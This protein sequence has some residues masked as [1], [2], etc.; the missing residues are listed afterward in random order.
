MG[1]AAWMDAMILEGASEEELIDS[2]DD[3]KDENKEGEVFQALP[4]GRR[5]RGIDGKRGTAHGRRKDES[6]LA[7]CQKILAIDCELLKL[8]P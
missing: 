8:Y 3:P 4:I 1:E 7:A 6:D 5:A 2:L